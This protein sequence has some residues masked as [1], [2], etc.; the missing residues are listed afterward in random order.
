MTKIFLIRHG[1]TEW[2]KIG[3]LQGS[4]DIKLLPEGI[5]QAHLLAEHAPF[6]NVHAI[7][8]SDLERAV[9]TAE[10]LA[11]KFGLSVIKERGLR[12]T[13]FGEWEGRFLSDLAK[14]NPK[15]FE[16][17]FTRPDKV[18]PPNGE[19]FLQSQARIMNA[20]DEI[21]ADNDDKSIIVVSH[22]AAIRLIL[23]AALVIP[24]RKMWAIGQYNMALNV[25]TFSEGNFSVELM[26]STLHLYNF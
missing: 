10:I 3:K 25:L 6:S 4:S 8:S 18:Q 23:C 7:Y 19:T 1:E 9:M 20:L 26:N 11:E 21:I 22:G 15:G 17:F 24:L 2:N 13:S 5:Q 16:K 12:E 14:E